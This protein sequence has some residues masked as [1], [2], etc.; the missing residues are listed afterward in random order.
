MCKP[1]CLS[2]LDRIFIATGYRNKNSPTRWARLVLLL[3]FMPALAW[4]ETKPNSD[5]NALVEKADSYR[6]IAESQR[7]ETRVRLFKNGELS[8]QKV[9][10]VYLRPGRKSLVLFRSSG[11]QGQKV[12]MLDDKFWLLMPKS[13]RPIR[14]TPMQKLLGEAS[15]GDIATMSWHDDYRAML[16][17]REQ[18]DGREIDKLELIAARKGVSYARI[19][20]YLDIGNQQPLRADLFVNSGKLA[21]SARFEIGSVDGRERV[22]RMVLTDAIQKGRVT[23]VEYLNNQP[24]EL[25]ER[26]FNPQYLARNP[27]LEP[28]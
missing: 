23:E 24:W 6:R 28:R 16:L 18:L 4:S 11:E 13:R 7:V 27:K 20:L 12:L 9:Y 14:I 25:A 5:A 17:G 21:K 10:H 26:F 1:K 8:K 19:E 3:A 15:T 22:T 2:V